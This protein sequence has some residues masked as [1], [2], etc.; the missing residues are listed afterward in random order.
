[1]LIDILRRVTEYNCR[2]ISKISLPLPSDVWLDVELKGSQL[3]NPAGSGGRNTQP[4]VSDH[5]MA[6][7][8]S[9]YA[10]FRSAQICG[11]V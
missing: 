5:H 2:L 1:M 4:N 11:E 6:I 9:G 7:A 10:L 8:F 3:F